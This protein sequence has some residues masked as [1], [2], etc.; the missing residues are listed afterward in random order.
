MDSSKLAQ[1]RHREQAEALRKQHEADLARFQGEK[2]RKTRLYFISAAVIIVLIFGG[3]SYSIYSAKF[4]PG[5]YD[6]FAKCLTDKGAVMYGAIGWCQYTKQQ[7]AWFGNSFKYV[8]YKDYKET[9]GIRKTPTWEINGERYEGVQSFDRLSQ[10]TGCPLS[11]MA[12]N[13]D[14]EAGQGSQ[15]V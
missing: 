7:A 4:K 3:L 8:N 9:Q 15:V 11:G 14:T 6:A 12:A 2:S 13:Q 1:Q 10:L 5:Q